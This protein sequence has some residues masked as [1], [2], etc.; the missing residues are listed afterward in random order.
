[1]PTALGLPVRR[2]LGPERCQ[3]EEGLGHKTDL[4]CKGFLCIGRHD[5][6]ERSAIIRHDTMIL[7]RAAARH[8]VGWAEDCGERLPDCVRYARN[9]SMA[10][11]RPEQANFSKRDSP[12]APRSCFAAPLM[13]SAGCYVQGERLR[14]LDQRW[15][16]QPS[17]AVLPFA[18]P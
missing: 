3:H 9:V 6:Q 14:I 10:A 16:G 11:A 8:A 5:R 13:I 12:T 18:P 7:A 15:N 1:M 2:R 17:A 4:G